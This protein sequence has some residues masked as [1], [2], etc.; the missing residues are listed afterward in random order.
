MLM[1][2]PARRRFLTGA[3]G[4]G[5]ITLL[6]GC[7]VTDGVSAENAL[8]YISRFNDRVQAMLFDPDQLAP[9]HDPSVI[10]RPFPFNAFYA[11]D[12]A[13]EIDGADYLLEVGG[14]VSEPKGW[15]LAEIAALPRETQITQHICIE[16]W[17]AIGKFEGVPLRHFLERVGADKNAA[18]VEFRCEDGYSTSLDMASALHPQTQLTLMLNDEPLPRRN[19]Y[20]IKVRV[21]T[22]LGFKNPKHIVEM[23][24]TNEYKD[25]FWEAYGYNWFSGL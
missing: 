14:M 4:L 11:E 17:S 22:K 7:E 10:T 24:V 1:P 16:G 21:P 23:I 2:S 18:Y 3:V 19:G 5:T 6:T 12:E 9:S 25:G 8:K 13:P 20:P 15:S